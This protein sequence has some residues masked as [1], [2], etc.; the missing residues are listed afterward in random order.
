MDREKEIEILCQTHK[1]TSN[2]NNKFLHAYHPN[3]HTKL[4]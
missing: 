1:K 4:S 3:I 2:K